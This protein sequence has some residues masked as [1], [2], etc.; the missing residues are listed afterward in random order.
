MFRRTHRT[1]H[2]GTLIAAACAI[3]ATLALTACEEQ[4]NVRGN[5]PHAEDIAKIR[6]G[7]HKKSDVE[8]LLGT[9]STVAAFQNETW[10]YIGGKN[11]T[12]SFFTM[13]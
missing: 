3:A 12:F 13:A 2:R 10:Y 7:F 4:V 11:K 1:K 8:N 6:P 9:P 5:I